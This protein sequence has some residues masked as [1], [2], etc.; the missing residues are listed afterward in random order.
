MSSDFRRAEADFG[1]VACCVG[2]GRGDGVRISGAA[3][4]VFVG[5][6]DDPSGVSIFVSTFM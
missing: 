4:G 2:C 3:S 1:C 6:Y 5:E